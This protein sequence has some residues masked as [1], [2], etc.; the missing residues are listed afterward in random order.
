MH[1][2]TLVCAFDISWTTAH[3]HVYPPPLLAARGMMTGVRPEVQVGA[4][5]CTCR[6]PLGEDDPQEIFVTRWGGSLGHKDLIEG[7]DL[8]IISVAFEVTD[9]D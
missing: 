3:L 6:C 1:H 7:L 4:N 2:I 9:S 8:N 5:I